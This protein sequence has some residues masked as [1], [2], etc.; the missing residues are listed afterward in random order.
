MGAKR[1]AQEDFSD[2]VA[3]HAKRCRNQIKRQEIQGFQILIQF[4]YCRINMIM[5]WIS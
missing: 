1:A 4:A 2:M 3:E 5:A